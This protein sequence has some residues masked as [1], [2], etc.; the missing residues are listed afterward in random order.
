MVLP[1]T[2]MSILCWIDLWRKGICFILF[3]LH[4]LPNRYICNWCCLFSYFDNI[5]CLFPYSAQLNLSKQGWSNEGTS[6]S[7]AC[8]S[9]EQLPPFGN[10][11]GSAANTPVPAQDASSYYNDQA[12]N[13]ISTAYLTGGD[14][15]VS[16]YSTAYFSSLSH[17]ATARP[18]VSESAFDSTEAGRSTGQSVLSEMHSGKTNSSGW[19]MIQQI[20]D[21]HQTGQK[22]T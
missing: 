22:G 8:D 11:E 14:N 12:S 18:L 15:S 20:L 6:P 1:S 9:T 21:L 19:N 3:F 10:P 13:Q 4:I 17:S 5:W 7:P 2:E 16:T